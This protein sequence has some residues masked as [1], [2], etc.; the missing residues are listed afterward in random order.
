M[1]IIDDMMTLVKKKKDKTFEKIFEFEK[2]IFDCTHRCTKAELK[3]LYDFRELLLINDFGYVLAAPLETV[4]KCELPKEEYK[5]S[6]KKNTLYVY[7]I[8]LVPEARGRGL[9][10]KMLNEVIENST[11]PRISLNTKNKIMKQMCL[12]FGFKQLSETYFV[13]VKK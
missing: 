13:L 10:K 5:H 11:K 6:G 2:R 3:R 9:G 12:D 1:N 8:G 4:R 7:S